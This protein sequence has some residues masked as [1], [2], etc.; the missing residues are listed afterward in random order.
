MARIKVPQAPI[1]LFI[2]L[3]LLLPL[4]LPAVA[5]QTNKEV[6]YFVQGNKYPKGLTEFQAFGLS[7][8]VARSGSPSYTGWVMTDRGDPDG[9]TTEIK[10][11]RLNGPRLSFTTTTAK[12]VVLSFNGRFLRRGDFRPYFGKDTPVIEG[13]VRKSLKGRK[14]AEG[15]MRFTCGIGG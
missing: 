5:Q 1:G 11:I 13:V 8:K 3:A 12:G 15:K 2:A 10:A 4:P 6:M 14:I 7:R 9:S